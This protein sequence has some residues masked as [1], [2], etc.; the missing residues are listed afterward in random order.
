MCI[1]V[2][3]IDMED[4]VGMAH[5]MWDGWIIMTLMMIFTTWV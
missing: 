3:A 1:F 2:D 5:A 4:H